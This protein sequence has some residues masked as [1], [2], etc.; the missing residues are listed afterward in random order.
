MR[1]SLSEQLRGLTDQQ[2][3]ARADQTIKE[4]FGWTYD[5]DQK[6]WV[7]D[8]GKLVMKCDPVEPEHE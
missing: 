3:L 1:G 6:G 4:G 7:D 5:P 8:N 2:L